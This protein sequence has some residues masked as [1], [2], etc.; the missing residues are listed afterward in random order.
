MM[1][2][3]SHKFSAKIKHQGITLIELMIVIS[4][5]MV[6]VALVGPLTFKM[7]DKAKAQSEFIELENTL[8]RISF[9]S[10][11]SATPYQVQFEQQRV[12]VLKNHQKISQSHFDY[13][14]FTP[15]QIEF[16]SRGYPFPEQ[17]TIDLRFKHTQLNLFK[18]V[19]GTDGRIK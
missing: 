17:L 14:V 10:F 7:V 13:L 8:K 19:E 12:V 4:L 5:M 3:F 16:N 9:Q 11:A 1:S 15:Q 6:V 18:L 2:T